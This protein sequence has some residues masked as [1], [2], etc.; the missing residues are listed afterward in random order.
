MFSDI[1]LED[2]EGAAELATALSTR[3]GIADRE[4]MPYYA[5]IHWITGLSGLILPPDAAVGK[6]APS[7]WG[8][9]GTKVGDGSAFCAGNVNFAFVWTCLSH[10]FRSSAWIEEPLMPALDQAT[11]AVPRSGAGYR[12]RGLSG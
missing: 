10:G 4:L 5:E 6:P 9:L 11:T 12:Q 3:L 8:L 2:V 7:S 1:G